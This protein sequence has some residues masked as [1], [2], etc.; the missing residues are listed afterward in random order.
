MN[1]VNLPYAFQSIAP[2]PRL[3]VVLL[4]I[5]FAALALLFFNHVGKKKGKAIASVQPAAVP[6]LGQKVT[7]MPAQVAHYVAPVVKQPT[8]TLPPTSTY[9]PRAMSTLDP[10]GQ[11]RAER[12]RK[13][14][15]TGFE[16]TH[17]EVQVVPQRLAG[18]QR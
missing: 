5:V 18:V 10:W 8:F 17:R 15:Q 11:M 13:A 14:I 7:Q 12:Y 4:V 9:T 16:E 3:K 1:S 2:N 6:S